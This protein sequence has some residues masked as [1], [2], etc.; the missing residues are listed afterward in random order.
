MSLWFSTLRPWIPMAGLVTAVL[1]ACG[2]TED[3]SDP[4][5]AGAKD[6]G[7]NTPPSF[8]NDDA[9]PVDDAGP[10]KCQSLNIGIL[11]VPGENASSDFQVWLKNAGTTTTRVQTNEKDVLTSDVLAPFDVVVIDRL[12]H[13]HSSAEA[14]AFKTW[15]SSGKGAM[16]MTGYLDLEEVDFLANPLLATVGL[17]YSK[18]WLNGPITSFVP[19]PITQG[20]TEM[21]FLG[22]YVI[23]EV[24]GSTATRTAIASASQGKVGYVAEL[25]QGRAFVWGDEWIQFDSEWSKL[26]EVQQF[27]VNIFGWLA[28][29]RCKLT[30]QVK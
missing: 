10:T 30:P 6:G 18:P 15:L 11:G 13:K 4:N 28:P 5:G 27:W 25:G 12:K 2:S 1:V 21:T 9:G 29:N 16:S 8:G 19:H 26:P 20:I 3:A 14:E 22:G 24:D 23:K 17:G 7:T